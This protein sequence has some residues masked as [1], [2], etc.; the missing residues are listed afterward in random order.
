MGDDLRTSCQRDD[1]CSLLFLSTLVGA[2]EAVV[3][4]QGTGKWRHSQCHVSAGGRAPLSAC[5]Y[6]PFI[7]PLAPR[8]PETLGISLNESVLAWRRLLLTCACFVSALLSRDWLLTLTSAHHQS[9]PPPG[10]AAFSFLSLP[11]SLLVS[12]GPL[13]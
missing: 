13:P 5:E 7:P 10:A 3:A 2:R 11:L 12:Q 6:V 8:A 1:S 4:R 9:L